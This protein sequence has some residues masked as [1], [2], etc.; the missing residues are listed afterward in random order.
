MTGV[1]EGDLSVA[2]LYQYNP[3]ERSSMSLNVNSQTEILSVG[4]WDSVNIAYKVAESTMEA[5]TYTYS[6]SAL[7]QFAILASATSTSASKILRPNPMAQ[8]MGR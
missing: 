6:M 2:A 3:A 5:T 1:G 8:L 4:T 7:I